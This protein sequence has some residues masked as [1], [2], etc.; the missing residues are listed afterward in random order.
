[1][2]NLLVSLRIIGLAAVVLVLLTA[3]IILVWPS[4]TRELRLRRRAKHDFR[5]AR[6]TQHLRQIDSALP[7]LQARIQAHEAKIAQLNKDLQNLG[8]QRNKMLHATLVR[9]LVENHLSDIRGIGPTLSSRIIHHCFRGRLSDLHTAY[10]VSGVGSALQ[11]SITAWIRYYEQRLPR[12]LQG[13]FPGKERIL[14]DFAAQERQLKERLQQERRGL[15]GEKELRR[16]TED[17]A[18]RLRAVELGDFRAALKRPTGSVPSEYLT[19]VYAPWEP[20][21][22]WFGLLLEEYGK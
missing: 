18:T 21:P 17:V 19:G 13:N 16:Q 15:A 20:M 6:G 1:M 7:N 3:A 8:Q 5:V 14:S 12:L 4:V 2:E 9:Y 10:R 22:E 11:S